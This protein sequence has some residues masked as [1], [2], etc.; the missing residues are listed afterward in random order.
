MPVYEAP[1]EETLFVLNDVLRIS[2]HANLTGFAEA[3]ADIV[4]ALLT[5]AGRFAK[6]V[7]LPLNRTGDIEGCI[8]HDDGSVTTPSGFMEAFRAFAEGG[9]IGLSSDP[10]YGGQG[11][12]HV[13]AASVT[14]FVNSANMAFGMYPG[15]T[16]GAATALTLHGSEE[17]KRLYVP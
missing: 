14:E 2:R 7:L 1:V 5:E 17:Q 6:E 4:E 13:L 11:L 3:S 15:L 12:P 9:W 10:D 8:R 16:H